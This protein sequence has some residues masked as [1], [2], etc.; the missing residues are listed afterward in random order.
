[1]QLICQI[2]LQIWGE[3]K[4]TKLFFSFCSFFLIRYGMG[5]CSANG[6][7]VYKAQSQDEVA[8]VQIAAQLQVLL[9]NK[10]GSAIGGYILLHQNF[11]T[12]YIQLKYL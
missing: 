1:M 7:L 9:C 3:A 2:V 4:L 12:S 5:W 11:V 8:L 10:M 6:A